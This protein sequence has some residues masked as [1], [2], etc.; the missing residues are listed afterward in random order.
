MI[1]LDG[2][3]KEGW[4]TK[5]KLKLRYGDILTLSKFIIS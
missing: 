5:K 3:K 1:G 2:K 4:E